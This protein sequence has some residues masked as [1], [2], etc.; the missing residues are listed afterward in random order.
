MYEIRCIVEDKKL[1]DVLRFLNDNKTLEPAVVIPVDDTDTAAAVAS[2]APAAPKLQKKS[3][4][5]K[6]IQAGSRLLKGKGSTQI[7]RDLIERT[8]V[9]R[10]TVAEMR[11]ALVAKGYSKNAYSHAIKLLTADRT[12]RPDNDLVGVY[13]VPGNLGNQEPRMV[14]G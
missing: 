12:I 8:G 5:K 4:R 1:R 3:K 2:A 9:E 13:N 7:I 11:E 6:P 14:M 10:I